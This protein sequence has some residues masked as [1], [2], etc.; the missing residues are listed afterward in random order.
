M[1]CFTR[2]CQ[3]HFTEQFVV[4]NVAMPKNFSQG[5]RPQ[6]AEPSKTQS[7]AVPE[8]NLSLQARIKDLTGK[9]QPD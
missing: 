3:D 8:L 4:I 7:K 5:S 1:K 2:R 9:K 6:H